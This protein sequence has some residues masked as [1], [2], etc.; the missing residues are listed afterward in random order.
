MKLYK[1]L[2]TTLLIILIITCTGSQNITISP[3]F[4]V[5]RNTMHENKRTQ[6]DQEEDPTRFLNVK[7][8]KVKITISVR[9]Q[10]TSRTEDS[11]TTINVDHFYHQ[12]FDTDEGGMQVMDPFMVDEEQTS[13]EEGGDQSTGIP[14]E[15]EKALQ[16]LMKKMDPAQAK[17][18]QE[19]LKQMQ[20]MNIAADKYKSW[21]V[22]DE[23]IIEGTYTINDRKV[24]R[25]YS[26]YEG[27]NNCCRITETETYQIHE[28][29]DCPNYFTLSI[30][31][32]KGVYSFV[33]CFSEQTV[34]LEKERKFSPNSCGPNKYEN[35]DSKTIGPTNSLMRPTGTKS[36]IKSIGLPTSGLTLSG[37]DILENFYVIEDPENPEGKPVHAEVSWYIIP[38]DQEFPEVYL[39]LA[40]EDWVPEEDNTTE[41]E[42]RWENVVPSQVRFS[43]T[44][45]SEE[46]GTCLNS[47][48][49]N[50]D[51]D[52]EIDAA[53]TGFEISENGT[54]ATKK[55][56]LPNK[57]ILIVKSRDY[58]AHGRVKAEIMV[59]GVWIPAE[60]KDP[61][62]GSLHLP[63][64]QNEN[65]IA[66]KWEK[67][68]G[69]FEDSHAP[70]WDED[71]EPTNQFSD[72]DGFTLYEE[73]RGFTET[74]NK[75]AKAVNVQVHKQHVRLD[76]EYKDVFIYD[77]D[78]L[79]RTHYAPTNA[80]NLN[81]HYINFD[82]M[83]K[84]GTL[85][86]DPEYRCVNF[87]TSKD[88][89]NR[90]QFALYLADDGLNPDSKAPNA[91]GVVHTHSTSNTKNGRLVSPIKSVYK[92]SVFPIAMDNMLAKVE[93]SVGSRVK[94]E[95][96]TTTV[97][98][99]VGHA[100]GI[101]HH[102][103]A[104]SKSINDD[105]RT[106]GVLNCAIR[107]ETDAERMNAAN[108]NFLKTRYCSKGE[109]W[110]M[111][112]TGTALAGH[113]CYG[114]IDI[115]GQ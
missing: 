115:K 29:F 54:V 27:C 95:L 72:G 79:F 76:P 5:D 28:E 56:P 64:D 92:V 3:A 113:D 55:N 65:H 10:V 6:F 86:T 68:I 41:V 70:D 17:K 111:P 71:P 75:L 14:S 62:G 20:G 114:Q 52:L 48:D 67:D 25:F 110:N 88:F 37:S 39:N 78:K 91:S 30:N 66:D 108:H 73:Y 42:L 32:D 102:W 89:Y 47:K 63:F 81:W 96:L 33:S 51:P 26:S 61:P 45:V 87:N 22:L 112:G 11:E 23:G 24:Y 57:E 107:N 9:G 8:W 1:T 59:D 13:D 12:I 38:T 105:S 36:L 90:D 98:H 35:Q 15:A 82:L 85:D 58:G 69:I 94:G 84:N 49:D 2:R 18:M 46:P 43:L 100:L 16:E 31:L 50:E 93:A 44:D 77:Q 97:I 21:N 99:E 109:T 104:A 101:R 103:D 40:D 83:Q 19:G 53:N 7:A 4:I 60:V 80:A 106:S 34:Q 74:D